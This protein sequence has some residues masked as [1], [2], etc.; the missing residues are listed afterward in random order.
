MTV[1]QIFDP[2]SCDS[3]S[4]LRFPFVR[5]SLFPIV[6]LHALDTLH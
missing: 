3:S 5:E 6:R 4:S 1:R 2:A